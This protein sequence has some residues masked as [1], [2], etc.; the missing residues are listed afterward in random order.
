MTKCIICGK[1]PADDSCVC[2][3]CQSKIDSYA[4][5]SKS[6]EAKY[7]LIYRGS[8]VGLY[9][10]GQ[11]KLKAK[12]L[13]RN[14]DKLPKFRTLNLDGYCQGY[15]REQIKRFKSCVLSLAH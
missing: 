3:N 15:S 14:P 2:H 10:D 8:V 12:L 11:G 4:R 9:S 6:P 7:F 1:R 13:S 5:A